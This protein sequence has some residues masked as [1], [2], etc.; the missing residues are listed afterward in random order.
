MSG[1][2]LGLVL[3]TVYILVVAVVCKY[4][5]GYSHTKF[6]KELMS[7]FR[8]LLKL[9]FTPSSINALGLVVLAVIILVYLFSSSFQKIITLAQDEGGSAAQPAIDIWALLAVLGTFTILCIIMCSKLSGR[10]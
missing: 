4:L 1:P 10:R 3:W 5:L 2:S 9:K 6:T 8:E 7:E